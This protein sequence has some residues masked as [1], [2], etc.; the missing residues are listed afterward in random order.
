M[1]TVPAALIKLYSHLSRINF[2]YLQHEYLVLIKHKM[3]FIHFCPIW[4]F[5][6]S[7]YLLCIPFKSPYV[8]GAIDQYE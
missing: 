8:L 3:C 5:L 6:V 2:L 1:L 7:I 4:W